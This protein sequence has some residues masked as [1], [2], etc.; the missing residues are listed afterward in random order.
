ME[1]QKR[2][3]YCGKLFIAHT[4]ATQYCSRQ[5]NGKDYKRKMREKEISD[6][7]ESNPQPNFNTAKKKTVFFH[8]KF[9]LNP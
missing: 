2:C 8:V 4:L 5:C 6:Y 1:I 7:L 3:K 9:I